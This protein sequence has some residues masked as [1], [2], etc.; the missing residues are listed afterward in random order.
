VKAESSAPKKPFQVVV[1]YD[2]SELS[3]RVVEEAL[4]V[5]RH[6]QPAE[7][8]VI[9]VAQRWDD[10]VSL[11]GEKDSGAEDAAR[12][13]VRARIARIVDE[14]NRRLGPLGIDRVA[15]YLD[16]DT[17]VR[18]TGIIIT[19]L[20]A[21]L[22]ADLIVVGTHAREGIERLVLGSVASQVVRHATT[23]VYVV[24]P[25]DFVHGKR[26]PTIQPPLA[27][28]EHPLR[29]FEHRRTYH[30]VDKVSA[31]TSRTMPAS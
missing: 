8:H 31:W 19:K 27:A 6:R 3:D 2:L 7:V 11:P 12:E 28:G 14:S 1:G 22:D 5:A 18:E 29:H 17:P 25:A 23:S 26:V 15:V 13:K 20:A 9:T 30:Y 16:A 24:Q 21:A 4:E 10:N